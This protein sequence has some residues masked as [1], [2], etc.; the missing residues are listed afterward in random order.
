ML[1]VPNSKLDN[2]NNLY[3]YR[4]IFMH[5]QYYL[6]TTDPEEVCPCSLQ[7]QHDKPS[8][9]IKTYYTIVDPSLIEYSYCRIHDTLHPFFTNSHEC[10]VRKNTKDT[11]VKE[12]LR[13]T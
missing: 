7:T 1:V 5:N 9:L 6:M 10:L 12:I 11:T 4:A 3:K 2:S 13:Q 8:T